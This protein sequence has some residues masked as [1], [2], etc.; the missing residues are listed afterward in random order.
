MTEKAKRMNERTIMAQK[1]NK[2][3]RKMISYEKPFVDPF[4]V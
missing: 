2:K 4:W 3:A 1:C